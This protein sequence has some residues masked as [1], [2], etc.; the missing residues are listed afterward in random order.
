MYLGGTINKMALFKKGQKPWNMGK[1]PSPETRKK[2]SES[3]KGHV[4]NRKGKTGIYSEETLKKMSESHKGMPSWNKGTKGILKPNSGSFKKGE[5]RSQETE[6]KKGQ[7]PSP[8]TEFKKGM[9]PHNKANGSINKGYRYKYDPTGK[10]RLNS[11][12]VAEKNLGRKLKSNE[13]IHHIDGNSLND[14]VTNLCLCQ[15]QKEHLGL[16]VLQRRYLN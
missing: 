3:L 5:H 12:I 9:T 6:F 7:R 1:S 14:S 2:I 13:I 4:S 11:R 16:H 8:K 15:S 10:Q